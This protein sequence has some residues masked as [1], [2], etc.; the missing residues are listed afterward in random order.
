MAK[1]IAFLKSHLKYIKNENEQHNG[2]QN[3]KQPTSPVSLFPPPAHVSP[4]DHDLPQPTPALPAPDSPIPAATL[5]SGALH[6]Q[7]TRRGR[8]G[9]WRAGEPRRGCGAPRRP[10]AGAQRRIQQAARQAAAGASIQ[11]RATEPVTSRS[12]KTVFA[13]Y[14]IDEKFTTMQ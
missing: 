12:V 6:G 4:L 2:L 10:G 8:Q 5:G 3:V 9:R 7:A 14:E 1:K 11:A 13:I